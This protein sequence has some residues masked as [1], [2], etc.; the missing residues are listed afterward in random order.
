[1][2]KINIYKIRGNFTILFPFILIFISEVM[3]HLN[4][5]LAPVLKVCAVIYMLIYAFFGNTFH[6]AFIFFLVFFI[7]IFFY[8]IIHSFNLSAGISEGVRYLF[9]V[10]I[11]MY[12]FAIRTRFRLLICAFIIFVLINDFWQIINYINWIRGEIQWFY[13]KDLYGNPKYN[14]SSGIL[15]ATGIVAFFGLFGFMNLIAFFI[16]RKYYNGKKKKLLLAI[17]IISLFLSF[18]YKSI[19]T[20]LVLLFIQ[21]KNKL[22]FFQVIGSLFVVLFLIMPKL[23][24]SMGESVVFRVE[25]YI[26]KGDS[27]RAES[28]RVM[29]DDLADFNLF[30]RGIGSFGGPSSVTY[31][32]PVYPDTNFNWYY[33][34]D[35]K[36]TDTFFPHLFVEVGFI[37]GLL[38]LLIILSPIFFRWPKDKFEIVVVI[39]VSLFL[40]ALFS[41]SLNN[42]AFLALSLSFLYPLFYF[43]GDNISSNLMLESTKQNKKQD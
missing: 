40:D 37:G 23:L 39:Y 36:T 43:N 25:Q 21:H 10:S 29:F 28:Y 22:R 30:G 42:I 11:L 17:F 19:G 9:P 14:M 31:N 33:T 13:L 2:A 27:A 8:G 26:T 20:F 3:M 4:P 18:S 1:M 38:Y 32:S 16:T 5:P 15:R 12:S 24:K 35:L 7:P 41:Y 34:I 6:T